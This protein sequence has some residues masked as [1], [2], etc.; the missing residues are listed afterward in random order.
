MHLV[1]ALHVLL[2]LLLLQLALSP[3]LPL[4]PPPTI[5]SHRPCGPIK[6]GPAHPSSLPTSVRTPR[7]VHS[8]RRTYF[9]S[10]CG[11]HIDGPV[12]KRRI[13]R[14]KDFLKQRRAHLFLF[15]SK[16]GK[17]VV[18]AFLLSPPQPGGGEEVQAQQKQRRGRGSRVKWEFMVHQT[19]LMG[20]R[21][22]VEEKRD[23]GTKEETR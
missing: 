2:L 12:V 16:D 13:P 7:A 22:S 11:W 15:L 19:T 14:V 3:E 4:T 10:F 21:P 18:L 20:R 23:G 9:T 17:A 5:R 6:Y 1:K 8:V